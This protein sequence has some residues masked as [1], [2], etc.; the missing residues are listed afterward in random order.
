MGC[1]WAVWSITE[2]PVPVSDKIDKMYASSTKITVEVNEFVTTF[3][4]NAHGL[5]NNVNK[6]AVLSQRLPR[7]ARYI[8]IS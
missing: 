8:S 5:D 3:I 1:L 6:K 4:H 2:P 7:D